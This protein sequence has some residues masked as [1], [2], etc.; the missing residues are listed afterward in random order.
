MNL[1][2]QQGYGH[3]WGTVGSVLT[4]E[5]RQD[6]KNPD[7]RIPD[8]ENPEKPELR[9]NVMRPIKL[10]L[11]S[12]WLTWNTQKSGFPDPENPENGKMRKISSCIYI[13]LQQAMRP[14]GRSLA[15]LLTKLLNS[16]LRR[17]V[18]PTPGRLWVEM[19]S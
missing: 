17:H 19:T 14:I 4:P 1:G 12:S 7:F 6:R 2:Q 10:K 8:P 9:K 3:M 15:S 16:G 18:Q 5:S 13:L 11:F